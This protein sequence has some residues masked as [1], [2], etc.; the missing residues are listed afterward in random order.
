VGDDDAH[1]LPAEWHED[2][3]HHR[4]QTSMLS[5]VKIMTGPKRVLA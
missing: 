5:S 2:M 4:R 1:H 3:D